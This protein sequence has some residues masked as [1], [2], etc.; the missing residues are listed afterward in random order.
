MSDI[1]N[2]AAAAKS[3]IGANGLEVFARVE[4]D[5]I[6]LKAIAGS[7]D[8]RLSA[9]VTKS[10]NIHWVKQGRAFMQDGVCPFCQTHV[11][12]DFDAELVRLLDTSYEQ[13]IA[14]LEDR[15][16]QYRVALT[17][18][19]NDWARISREAFANDSLS[20]RA[21][22]DGLTA[23]LQAN[24][25][26]MRGKLE[27]P[28]EPVTFAS[29]D[30]LVETL[31]H[32]LQQVNQ[33]I[34]D[35]NRRISDRAAVEDD[36]RVGF[37][38]R[39]KA[40]NK[41]ALVLFGDAK[42]GIDDAIQVLDS[43]ISAA[44][45][46]ERVLRTQVRELAARSVGTL[47]AVGAINARLTRMGVSGF[48]IVKHADSDNLYRL[49]RPGVGIGEYASLSEGEKTLISFLYFVELVSGAAAPDAATPLSRKIVVVDDPISSLS[50]N[51][52]YDV[53]TLIAREL[54]RPGGGGA[55]QVVV[56]THS[57][58]FYHELLKQLKDRHVDLRRVV[59]GT[60]SQVVPMGRADILSDYA[61]YW[62][63]LKDAR[64]NFTHVVAVPN[65]MRCIF[66]HF[67]A[68]TDRREEFR[69]AL[70]HL[71]GDDH[72]FTPL[73]R[74]LNRESHADGINLTDF[75]EYDLD[76]FMNKFEAVFDKTGY[77]DHFARWMRS[78]EP[79][80]ADPARP[81]AAEGA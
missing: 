9:L 22:Y 75:G 7:A 63:I 29:T 43:D 14:A 39:L 69:L 42:R 25:L 64:R 37:W 54:V 56:L 16:R 30:G 23:A 53:A 66:E 65:A 44:V 10:K 17:G 19:E 81:H 74:Y 55:R 61:A 4:G 36:V 80:H 20:L 38:K 28:R 71:E 49:A 13:D 26:L 51:Y 34:D 73:A 32:A 2:D 45:E 8:S 1:Q 76:Y 48:E 50:H 40:D 67:F 77:P 31:R 41:D 3:R 11:A 5:S 12:D 52:V 21:A 58:F 72:R 24:R 18:L 27:S 6:W 78:D 46:R 68:F 47:A 33:R 15:E 79:E 57:L 70:E 62:Q 60:H 35:F 59:K